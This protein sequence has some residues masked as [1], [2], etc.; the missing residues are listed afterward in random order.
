MGTGLAVSHSIFLFSVWLVLSFPEKE[1]IDL[2]TKE[3]NR[4]YYFL[5]DEVI[6]AFVRWP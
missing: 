5:K 4:E 3:K 1:G 6:N 2:E